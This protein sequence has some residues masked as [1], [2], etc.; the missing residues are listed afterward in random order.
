MCPTAGS[1]HDIE[2]D[3]DAVLLDEEGAAT[4][5]Q[6]VGMLVNSAGEQT[7][8]EVVN[9]ALDDAENDLDWAAEIA[10]RALEKRQRAPMLERLKTAL[11]DTFALGSAPEVETS[12]T[13]NEESEHMA[14]EKQLSELWEKIDGLPAALSE[15]LGKAVGEAV[16]N[17][18][19]PLVDAQAKIEANQKAKDEAEKS[20]LVNKVVK[21]NVLTEEVA[22][23]LELPALK[24]L[25]AKAEPGRAYGLNAAFAGASDKVDT[26]TLLPEGDD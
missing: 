26:T 13:V 25:A 22:R 6:G 4:P 10:A 17:A 16:A 14:D 21:A 7:E 12:P 3:H 23:T 20:A 1:P 9:S 19:K 11:R 2:F 8:I 24:E 15:S 18:V 5:A